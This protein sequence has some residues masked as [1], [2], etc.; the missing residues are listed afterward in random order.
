MSSLAQAVLDAIWIGGLAIALAAASYRAWAQRPL[1]ASR[2]IAVGLA[3]AFMGWGI[4]QA[5]SVWSLV[6]C[7]SLG[8]MFA[9]RAA[10]I[11]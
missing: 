7:V 1:S 8:L 3:V 6:A 11:Y 9:T 5:S 4:A 10:R 2:V